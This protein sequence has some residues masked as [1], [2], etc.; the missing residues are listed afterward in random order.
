MRIFV[1]GAAALAVGLAGCNSTGALTPTQ[2]AVVTIAYDSVCPVINGK[3]LAAQLATA[4]T[5]AQG[6]YAAALSLCAKGAPTSAAE[7]GYDIAQTFVILLPYLLNHGLTPNK[8]TAMAH[9]YLRSDHPRLDAATRAALQ[10]F[11]ETG[12]TQ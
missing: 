3:A 2:Q 7:G 12:A 1:I 8:A 11:V 6:A 4:S 10:R 9:E 5:T